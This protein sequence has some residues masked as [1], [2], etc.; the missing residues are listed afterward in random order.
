MVALAS[1]S[2]LWEVTV[3]MYRVAKKSLHINHGSVIGLLSGELS[4][5]VHLQK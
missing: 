2:H 4:L 1:V 3:I 5:Q